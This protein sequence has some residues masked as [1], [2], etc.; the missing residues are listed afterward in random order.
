MKRYAVIVLLALAGISLVG[1]YIVSRGISA[2]E[3]P[4]AL[5]TFVARRLRH[6]AIPRGA[7][8]LRNPVESSPQVLSA[9]TAHFADHCASCHGNDGRGETMIG[10][11]LYPK[12]PDMTGTDTQEL[13]DGELYYIIENGVRFTGMPAFGEE[14]GNEAN[15][16]SWHLVHFIRHLPKLS[17]DE[18]AAMKKMNPTSPMERAREE[19]MRKFLEGDDSPPPEETHEHGH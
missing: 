3:K 8:E 10:K 2:R 11:G 17:D 15:E 19:Q 9:G 18:V 7:R 14:E 12:P 4:G 1:V 16:E 5:E 13:T 6:L